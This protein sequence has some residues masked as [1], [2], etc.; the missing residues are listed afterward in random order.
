MGGAL[1]SIIL[2]RGGPLTCEWS[3]LFHYPVQGRFSNMW[4]MLSV[5]L[6]CAGEVL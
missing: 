1:C 4:V 6:F 2:C 3:S 5:L